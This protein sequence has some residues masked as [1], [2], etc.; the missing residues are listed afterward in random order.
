MSLSVKLKFP[1]NIEYF[2]DTT[3]PQILEGLYL[4]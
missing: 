1:K 3:M 2:F 4:Y